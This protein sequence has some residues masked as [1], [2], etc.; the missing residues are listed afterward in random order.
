MRLPT[1]QLWRKLAKVNELLGY[2]NSSI[3]RHFG[4][5]AS[6]IR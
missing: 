3:S 2:L 5:I 1:Y 6:F 4:T